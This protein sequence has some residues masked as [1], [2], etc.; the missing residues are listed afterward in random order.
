MTAI[1]V[2]QLNG[3]KTVHL[4]LYKSAVLVNFHVVSPCGVHIKVFVTVGV[5]GA[6]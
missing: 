2:N 4:N 6:E 1:T 3:K 5:T